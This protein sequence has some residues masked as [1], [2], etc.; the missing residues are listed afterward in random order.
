LDVNGKGFAVVSVTS[1]TKVVILDVS[2]ILN[3]SQNLLSVG[4]MLEKGYSLFFKD[5]KCIIFYSYSFG[6]E[7]FCAKMNNKIFT[8]DWEKATEWIYSSAPQ[9][10]TNCGLK[11]LA[12]TIGETL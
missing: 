7:L 12:A 10:V 11:D 9:M 8:L 1:G 4:Q 5:R 3:I 2:N 6:V